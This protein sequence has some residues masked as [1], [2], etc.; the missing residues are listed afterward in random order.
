MATFEKLLNESAPTVGS[1]QTALCI[2]PP[3]HLQSQIDSLRALYDK[4]HGKW[5]PHI[6]LIYP[7]VTVENLPG[8][9]D[10]IS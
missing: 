4:A 9:M 2:I 8:A 6:N 1:Y 7:F 5:P 3:A 10:L